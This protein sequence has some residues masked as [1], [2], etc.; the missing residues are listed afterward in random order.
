MP[1]NLPRTFL[2]FLCTVSAFV[3][4]GRAPGAINLKTRD[5]ETIINSEGRTGRDKRAA[6]IRQ[7]RS[8]PV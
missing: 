5:L 6:I 7:D 3:T 8:R 2:L 1:V 4:L